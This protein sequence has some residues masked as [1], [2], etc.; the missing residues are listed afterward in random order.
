MGKRS[1]ATV[2]KD[3]MQLANASPVV[4]RV[5]ATRMPKDTVQ[6]LCCCSRALLKGSVPL[7][8]RQKEGL[9]PYATDLHKL[10]S[11]QTHSKTKQ[12]ILQKGGLLRALVKAPQ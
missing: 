6:L 11:N 12:A 1:R 7:D 10:A 9:R 2:V 4:R 5:R 8:E 3:V